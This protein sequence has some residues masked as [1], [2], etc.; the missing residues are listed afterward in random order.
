MNVRVDE[1]RLREDKDSHWI[2]LAMHHVIC[3][4]EN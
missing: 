4:E 3:Y 2:S 1:Y